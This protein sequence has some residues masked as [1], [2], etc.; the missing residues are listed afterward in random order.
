MPSDVYQFMLD[1]G[2]RT[3]AQARKLHQEAPVT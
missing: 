3:T 2:V 1:R